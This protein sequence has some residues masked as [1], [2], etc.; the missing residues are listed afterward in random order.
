VLELWYFVII[1]L[2]GDGGLVP[3]HAG[4]GNELEVRFMICVLLYFT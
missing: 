1:K 2:R 4:I 3:K